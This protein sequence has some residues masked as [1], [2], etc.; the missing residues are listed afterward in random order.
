MN[1]IEKLMFG[2][3]VITLIYY[4]IT[5]LLIR[6]ISVS[7]IVRLKKITMIALMTFIMILNGIHTACPWWLCAGMIML[8]SYLG[9]QSTIYY[10]N[11]NRWTEAVFESDI[12]LSNF[13]QFIASNYA[14]ERLIKINGSNSTTYILNEVYRKSTGVFVL[15]EHRLTMYAA[16]KHI[17]TFSHYLRV[18][19]PNKI[20]V[21]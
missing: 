18:Q 5:R 9:V 1:H 2:L 14:R 10:V 8:F 13:Q 17:K 20:P 16:H 11:Q 4:G 12:A 6:N 19:E 15:S 7:S 3:A 21:L